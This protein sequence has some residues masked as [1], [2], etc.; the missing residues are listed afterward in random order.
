MA[1]AAAY[2]RPPSSLSRASLYRVEALVLR[3]RRLGEADRV[4][5]LFTREHGKLQAVVRGARKIRSRMGGHVEPLMHTSVLL[6]RGR[7]LDIVT[8]AQAVSAFPRVRDDLLAA[9]RGLL[10]AEIV[11]RFSEEHEPNQAL[12]AHLIEGLTRLEAVE[13]P[14][15]LVVRAFETGVLE[16][17]G[18]RPVLDRCVSC[19]N[20]PGDT[21]AGPLSFGAAWGGVLCAACAAGQDRAALRP[22]SAPALAGLR[23]LQDRGYLA[24]P[25]P[26]APTA[27]STTAANEVER[28]LRW[29]LQ[30]VLERP[31]E[32]AAF[33][34]QLRSP[35]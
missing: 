27:T 16:L 15:E 32:T 22:L 30:S 10:M 4:L 17:E 7:S 21:G 23:T 31:L 19:G 26:W 28:L 20:S 18:Y 29:H 12:F 6:V 14:P 33:L 8:Q 5:T 25:A 13:L 11:E 34:D 24:D 9:T 2:Q 35:G 1:S 3:H